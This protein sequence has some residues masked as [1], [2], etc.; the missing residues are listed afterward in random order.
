[1]ASRHLLYRCFWAGICFRFSPALRARRL[2]RIGAHHNARWRSSGSCARFPRPRRKLALVAAAVWAWP[3]V[4]GEALLE[5]RG[6][7]RSATVRHLFQSQYLR[8]RSGFGAAA[9]PSVCRWRLEPDAQ[10]QLRHRGRGFRFSLVLP[11]LAV[12]SSKGGLL[13]AFV[14]TSLVTVFALRASRP[15]AFKRGVSAQSVARR[16][17]WRLVF[18][19][20]GGQNRRAALVGGARRR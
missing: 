13:A 6:D 7:A 2:A 17:A 1:M 4:G 10:S 12:T 11:A 5:L 14:G 9:Y 18:G 8:Q 19:A 16:V 15:A 20:L 3:A